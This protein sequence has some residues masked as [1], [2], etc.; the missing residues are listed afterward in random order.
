MQPPIDNCATPDCEFKQCL[1]AGT[2]L[3]WPCSQ[4]KLGYTELQ[5]RYH[6]TRAPD[7]GWNGQLA[8]EKV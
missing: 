1:W 3:C 6:A 7:G 4:A 5:R 8:P 2:G